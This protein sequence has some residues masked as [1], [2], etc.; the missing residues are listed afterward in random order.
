[1]Y[2]SLNHYKKENLIREL[3]AYSARVSYLRNL[4]K[5]IKYYTLTKVKNLFN[6]L[7]I[8]KIQNLKDA[9][10]LCKSRF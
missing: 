8:Q 4:R 1:M 2:A 10:K 5:K 9:R 3:Q 7:V 6:K